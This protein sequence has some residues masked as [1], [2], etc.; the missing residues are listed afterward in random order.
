MGGLESAQCPRWERK[1]LE[2]GLSPSQPQETTTNGDNHGDRDTCRGPILESLGASRLASLPWPGLW[3][4]TGDMRS[5][6]K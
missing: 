1:G 6:Y 4:T 3:P 2:A 5:H